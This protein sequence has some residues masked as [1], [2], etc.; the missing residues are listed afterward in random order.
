LRYFDGGK[1]K[2]FSSGGSID[3]EDYYTKDEI[4]SNFYQKE[5]SDDSLEDAVVEIISNL[6]ISPSYNGGDISF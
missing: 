3:L 1:W 5:D 6:E 2:P 4:K